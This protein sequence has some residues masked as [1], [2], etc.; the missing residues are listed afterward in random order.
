MLFIK[1]L[2]T[3]FASVFSFCK[4]KK[5]YPAAVLGIGG[6]LAGGSYVLTDYVEAKHKEAM[7]QIQENR[8]HVTT[9]L[10]SQT[11]ILE[12]LQAIKDGV[13]ETKE[14]VKSLDSKV[15]QAVLKHKSER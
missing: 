10:V 11:K 2:G 3:I 8:K 5:K 1:F 9:I 15:W 14:Q 6:T 12:N 13:H 4:E 7:V